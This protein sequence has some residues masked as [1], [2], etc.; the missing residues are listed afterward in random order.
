MASKHRRT[1]VRKRRLYAVGDRVF[2]RGYGFCVI[3][4]VWDSE[5]PVCYELIDEH[6]PLPLIVPVDQIDETV[7][8][9]LVQSVRR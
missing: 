8:E 1:N 2:V 3:T 9:Q 5:E 7:T 4:N 6:G